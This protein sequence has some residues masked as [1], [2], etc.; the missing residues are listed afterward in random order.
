MALWHK[1]NQKK[2]HFLIPF[3]GFLGGIL[4]AL[5]LLFLSGRS[6]SRRGG[7]GFVPVK[8]IM[9]AAGYKALPCREG[10][11]YLFAKEDPE[12]TVCFNPEEETA[13]K[14]EYSFS[15]DHQLQERRFGLY[16]APSLLKDLLDVEIK[17]T[18]YFRY[19]VT[20]RTHPS[21]SLSSGTAP[22]ISALMGGYYSENEEGVLSFQKATYSL[23]A[24]VSNYGK[25]IRVFE[26]RFERTSDGVLVCFHN[27]ESAYG[28]LPTYK[29]F[30][31]NSPSGLTQM[32]AEALLTQM[33]VNPDMFVVVSMHYGA[34]SLEEQQEWYRLLLEQASS[35]GGEDLVCRLIPMFYS[36]KERTALR[37]V[38]EWPQMIFLPKIDTPPEAPAEGEEPTDEYKAALKAY[39]KRLKNIA[40]F[41]A[42]KDDVPWVAMNRALVTR[43]YSDQ[44]HEL[45][46]QVLATSVDRVDTLYIYL[47]AG[48]DGF[49]TN[50][51]PPE[52]YRT[53]LLLMP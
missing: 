25:G 45:G 40:N 24:L 30:L 27:L 26:S 20:P 4:C 6:L 53:Q 19:E 2:T 37:E 32:S 51:M 52:G 17:K 38:R 16:A 47:N 43:D 8:P 11:N 18:G 21:L 10:N 31:E 3:L 15:A 23:E 9:T 5:L 36:S 39:K 14:N 34:S 33:L 49:F 44:L 50:A 42:D 41:L 28:H 29:E 48:A 22:F 7:N 13:A 35:M 46:K 1:S 12:I